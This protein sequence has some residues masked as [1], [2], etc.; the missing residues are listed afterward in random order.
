[1]DLAKRAAEFS[2]IKLLA[3]TVMAPAGPARITKRSACQ[4]T[5]YLVNCAIRQANCHSFWGLTPEMT[6]EILT[7]EIPKP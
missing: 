6:P 7:P 2:G 5:C 3:I 4:K 1:M